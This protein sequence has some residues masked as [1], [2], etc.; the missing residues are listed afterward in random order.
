LKECIRRKSHQCSKISQEWRQEFFH[1]FWSQSNWDQKKTYVVNHV[2]RIPKKKTY[3]DDPNNSK[4]QNTFRYLTAGGQRLEICKGLF[5][6]TTGL[7][8][9]TILSWVKQEAEN[10]GTGSPKSKEYKNT[11]RKQPDQT[12]IQRRLQF[13][14]DFFLKQ[15]M[16]PSHYARANN[17]KLF[18]EPAF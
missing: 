9:H 8:H 7:G 4:R 5:M 10:G 6:S 11:I 12:I 3:A 17:K 14:K 15:P 16:L 1:K 18:L 2:D 13:T